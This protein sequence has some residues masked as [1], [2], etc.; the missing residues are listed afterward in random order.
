MTVLENELASMKEQNTRL[1]ERN[2]ALEQAMLLRKEQK[3]FDNQPAE[4]DG[5]YYVSAHPRWHGRCPLRSAML[6]C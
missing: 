1:E 4:F 6:I 2:T 5:Q 3:L